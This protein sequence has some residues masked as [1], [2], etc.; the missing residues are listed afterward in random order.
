M[1]PSGTFLQYEGKAIGSGSEGAQ[2]ALQEAYHKVFHSIVWSMP[3]EATASVTCIP[4]VA[5]SG[6]IVIDNCSW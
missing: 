4:H 6:I 1:D 5:D 2:Q 3:L